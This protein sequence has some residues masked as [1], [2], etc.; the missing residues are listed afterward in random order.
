MGIN[1]TG[2]DMPPVPIGDCMFSS[3][4]LQSQ[5]PAFSYGRNDTVL[6]KYSITLRAADC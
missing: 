4:Q 1:Q 5:L 3:G 6:H 2:Q